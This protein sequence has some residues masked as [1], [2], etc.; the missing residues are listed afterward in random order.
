MRKRKT[1]KQFVALIMALFIIV[2]LIPS[3]AVNAEDI[4]TGTDAEYNDETDDK[5]SVEISDSSDTEDISTTEETSE[6]VRKEEEKVSQ[7]ED[8]EEIEVTDSNLSEDDTDEED[9]FIVFDHM[10]SD[11]DASQIN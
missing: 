7:E 5:P 8:E 2:S 6:E 9:F 10:Y 11:V 4:A 1:F 3:S